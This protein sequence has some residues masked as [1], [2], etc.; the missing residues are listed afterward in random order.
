MPVIFWLTSGLSN[1]H[2]SPKDVACLTC[3]LGKSC[4]LGQPQ[5]MPCGFPFFPWYDCMVL[6]A[7]PSDFPLKDSI[8]SRMQTDSLDPKLRQY[9]GSWDCLIKTLRHEGVSGLYRGFWPCLLRAAPV[10]AATF[11]AYEYA[12][13]LLGGR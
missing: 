12:M 11:V 2:R 6:I 8:K 4:L 7:L 1:G 3:L 9:S 10:N 13:H 5:A